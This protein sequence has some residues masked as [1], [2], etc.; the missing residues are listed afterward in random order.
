MPD[1]CVLPVCYGDALHGMWKGFEELKA[2]G[3]IDRV[4]RFVAAEVS[5]SLVNA[6]ASAE[7]MPMPRIR[8][9]AT[10]ATSIGANQGTVQSLEVLRHSDGA[11][12]EVG[13]RRAGPMGREARET[14]RHRAEPSPL[15]RSSPSS[16]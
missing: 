16:N 10:I 15:R 14:R 13:Q 8:N 11:A 5:G 6:L 2:L 9:T 12:F 1:W 7:K 4:P 3:W